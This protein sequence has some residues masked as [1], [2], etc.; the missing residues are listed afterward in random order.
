MAPLGGCPLTCSVG[1][2]GVPWLAW[3]DP[4]NP[5]DAANELFP[6]TVRDPTYSHGF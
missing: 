4:S 5:I 3:R 1:Q 2:D 6:L